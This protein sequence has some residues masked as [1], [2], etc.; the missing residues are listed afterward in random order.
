MLNYNENRYN[1][2]LPEIECHKFVQEFCAY[3]GFYYLVDDCKS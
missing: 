2:L 1:E 3:D